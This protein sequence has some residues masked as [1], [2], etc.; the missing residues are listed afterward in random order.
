VSSN[1]T[2]FERKLT[3]R[4]GLLLSGASFLTPSACA[5][6]GVVGVGKPFSLFLPEVSWLDPTIELGGSGTSL[7]GAGVGFELEVRRLG[8]DFV[9]VDFVEPLVVVVGVRSASGF[10]PKKPKIDF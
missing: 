10:F 5:L 4:E 7:L 8:V 9:K 1:R 2:V 3:F 6:A